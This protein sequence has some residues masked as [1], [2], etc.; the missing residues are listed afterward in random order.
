[1]MWSSY[2]D[3]KYTPISKGGYLSLLPTMYTLRPHDPQAYLLRS[4]QNKNDLT[5][6]PLLILESSSPCLQYGHFL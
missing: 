3:Y 4:S 2:L 6:G 1:M 5:R